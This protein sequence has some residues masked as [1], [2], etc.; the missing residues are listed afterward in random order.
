MKR[1]LS[2]ALSLILL[3]G[4]C[5]VTAF[6]AEE[7]EEVI[8]LA[9]SD[10]QVDGYN[11]KKMEK[12][13]E[14]LNEFG[15]SKADGI[16][17]TG[18][19]TIKSMESNTSSEGIEVLKETYASMTDAKN[20]VFVQGNHD[21]EETVGL[22]PEGNNDPATGAYGVYVIHE[23]T[24]RE[25][26]NR[27]PDIQARA[28]DMRKYFQAKLD[29]GWTKPIF[30]VAHIGLHWGNRTV[31]YGGNGED[32]HI[33]FDVINEFGGK[34]LNIFYLYGHNHSG[35]YDDFLG[36]AA[37][38]LKKGD[39]INICQGQRYE[40]KTETLNFTYMTSGYIGY[41]GTTDSTNKVDD[42]LTMSA[43]RIRGDEVIV[44]RYSSTG[45]HNL[46]SA[47]VTHK[48]FT[49]DQYPQPNTL[50]YESSRLVTAT[51]DV[52]VETPFP[53]V[54]QDLVITELPYKTTYLVGEELDLTGLVLTMVYTNQTTEIITE[55][56]KTR[57]FQS[58]TTGTRNLTIT[59]EGCSDS[60]EYEVVEALPEEPVEPVKNGWVNEDGK[61]AYYV[62]DVKT[63][64]KWVA[65]SKGWCYLD[66]NG[67]MAT[68]KWIKDSVGWC[69]VG[70]NGYCVTNKWVAD[71]KGW[72]YLD[73]NGRMV[74]NKWIKDSV[75]WCYVG[76]DGYCV[77]NKWV[78]DSKGWCYLD[79]SGR[80]VTNKWVKDSKGWCYIG[81]AGYCLT[82]AWV[83]D[84]VGW[85][86]LD[87]NGRMV[88]NKWVADGGKQYYINASGYMVT[89][90][91]TIG[92]KTYTFAAN[93][94]LIA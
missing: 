73:G 68:N 47:G 63:T 71:S 60:F 49:G 58:I 21:H 87:G 52:W 81:E 26:G 14:S 19:Y 53:P 34:G 88:Y 20:M 29:S 43:F 44:T 36:G 70:D 64:N 30:V 82:N 22:S 4:M 57:G 46:K 7:E 39:E 42:A 78:A 79:A 69:Y 37:V 54:P 27:V 86:Y 32:G 62:D 10:F 90:K 51:D 3:L 2:I 12:L 11:T 74:T 85:C 33:L 31:K 13:I 55:G 80:M 59:Y 93:G 8:V 15:I 94:A 35:G 72:C 61:W 50:V 40:Y 75:G 83:K 45:V 77:T 18:D 91:Q 6:A 66:A 56:Y 92:G 23:D 48:D 25:W 41:Y 16:L 84:S 9:G 67:Y 76:A 1:L 65:D 17:F 24:Y 38:Y 5:S 89:G 28:D